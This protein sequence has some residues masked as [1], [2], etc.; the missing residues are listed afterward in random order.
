MK[1]THL[2]SGC[3]LALFLIMA[4]AS[5]TFDPAILAETYGGKST[6]S[7]SST[8]G[9]CKISKW[10][11]NKNGY[12]IPYFQK[13]CDK[14]LS[15]DYEL[16]YLDGSLYMSGHLYFTASDKNPSSGHYAKSPIKIVIT[17]GKWE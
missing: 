4:I 13:N 16:Y 14:S 5:V 8:S 6:S 12:Y 9:D 1:T 11:E 10:V 15:L 17:S 7:S 3:G 2:I